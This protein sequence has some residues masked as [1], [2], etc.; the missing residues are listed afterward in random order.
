MTNQEF[1]ENMLLLVEQIKLLTYGLDMKVEL[2]P[3][4]DMSLPKRIECLCEVRLN[5]MSY[6]TI[7]MF[8]NTMSFEKADIKKIA[9]SLVSSFFADYFEALSLTNGE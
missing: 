5:C 6:K 8:N 7:D 1:T 4:K 2:S 3:V 9:V